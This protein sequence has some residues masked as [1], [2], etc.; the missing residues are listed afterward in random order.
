MIHQLVKEL[1][2]QSSIGHQIMALGTKYIRSAVKYCVQ[3]KIPV[4]RKGLKLQ[5]TDLSTIR[6]PVPIIPYRY[7][8]TTWPITCP[9]DLIIRRSSEQFLEKLIKGTNISQ[10][11]FETGT[12]GQAVAQSTCFRCLKAAQL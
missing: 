1:F 2:K 5:Y 8:T 12:F 11:N 10:A 3:S 4:D 6:H 9:H 7:G